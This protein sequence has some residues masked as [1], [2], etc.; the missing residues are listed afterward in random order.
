MKAPNDLIHD[1][2]TKD[3]KNELLIKKLT[4]VMLDEGKNPQYHRKQMKL[5]RD[6]WKPLYNSIWD[7]IKF[8]LK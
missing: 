7:I 6:N 5:L 8:N 1:Q 4:D 2:E 3:A